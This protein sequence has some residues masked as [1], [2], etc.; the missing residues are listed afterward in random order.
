MQR[1]KR[2]SVFDMILAKIQQ[3]ANLVPRVTS[4][5]R[6]L[7]YFRVTCPPGTWS[8]AL[9]PGQCRLCRHH[10][11]VVLRADTGD[12]MVQYGSCGWSCRPVFD[13][14]ISRLGVQALLR[15]DLLEIAR[16]K[17]P[18]DTEISVLPG[19]GVA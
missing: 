5:I 17:C 1:H 8:I 15:A 11:F 10:D 9:L 6:I 7:E 19:F 14:F 18:D 12:V 3:F 2:Y 4:A 13:S 16:V